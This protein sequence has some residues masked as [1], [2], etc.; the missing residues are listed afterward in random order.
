MKL[1]NN[2]LLISM[3]VL[4][5]GISL[6]LVVL[7][8]ITIFYGIPC[9][10]LYKHSCSNMLFENFGLLFLLRLVLLLVVV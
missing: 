7:Y 8:Y 5:I 10:V 6:Y 9:Q 2:L 3:L 4:A 1:R